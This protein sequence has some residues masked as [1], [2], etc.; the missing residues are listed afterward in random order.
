MSDASVLV[1]ED[2]GIVAL[3]LSVQLE[4]M[5][6]TVVGTAESGE[7][8]LR[9]AHAH[10]PQLVLMDVMLKGSMNGI[11]A[12]TELRRTLNV[13]VI[14]LTSYSDLDTV[15]RAAQ[16]APYGYLTKPYNVKELRAAIHVAFAKANADEQVR[17]AEVKLRASEEKF[18][19]AFDFAP[20]GMAI[21]GMDGRITQ[22][23]DALCRFLGRSA[24]ELFETAIDA[25]AIDVDAE[26]SAQ[27]IEGLV[28]GRQPA[29]QF[30]QRYQHS[31][32]R[33]RWSQVSVSVL[34]EA[35][36]PVCLLYQIHDV[37]ERKESEAQ[38]AR[39]AYHDPLTGL[40]NRV[41]LREELDRLLAFAKRDRKQLAVVF[42]DLDRF[43]QINDTL[44]H[45]AGD[46][47]LQT[48]ARRLTDTLRETDCVARLGGDEFV[49]VLNGIHGPENAVSVL[50]KLRQV[51]AQPVLIEGRE[52]VVTPSMGVSMFPLDGTDHALLLR[53]A[54]AA[55]YASKA[56]GR[57][58]YSFFELELAEQAQHR[59]DI[60]QDLRQAVADKAFHLEYQP[61]CRLD[62]RSLIRLEALVRW[63]RQG[64]A[65]E[66]G[67]FIPIAEEAGLIQELGIWVLNEACTFA[68]SL[69]RPVPVSINC[70]ALQLDSDAFVDEVEAVLKRTGLAPGRLCI[71]LTES[72][73]LKGGPGQMRRLT[74]LRSLGV[75][76]AV[77]DY[78]TGH[79]PLAHLQRYAFDS[80]K[81]DRRFINDLEENNNSRAIVSATVAM[82]HDLG[83]D[84]VAEGVETAGQAIQ[85][86]AM[87]CDQA[88]GYLYHRPMTASQAAELVRGRLSALPAQT[89]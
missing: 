72:F 45:E 11:E 44:G 87:G 57:N 5:G 49:L 66:P 3:D 62:D 12:A 69:E 82:A 39:L 29:I 60:E 19:N 31:D 2:E 81:V 16:A 21:V 35:D 75:H 38:M 73:M 80:L 33:Q 74:R 54:D 84:V 10:R 52:V 46:V 43:K 30:E 79:S 7:E 32:G 78:G 77:D 88:Q 89:P 48:V 51:I 55:L 63:D 9:L 22:A 64:R 58:R 36:Q 76:L 8:A 37:T 27:A 17:A 61:I 86:Q 53:C 25:H 20:L 14:F 83:L 71:E 42:M 50:E 23:N 56:A 1:V 41:R 4:E 18:R 59:L 67:S 40:A 26:K 13:P 65:I 28:Q 24:A 70:S 68:A 85:L 34:H 6:Y 47:L 15:N